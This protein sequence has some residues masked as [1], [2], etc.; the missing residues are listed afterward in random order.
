M[1]NGTMTAAAL[2][3]T[4]AAIM[5]IH[6]FFPGSGQRTSDEMISVLGAI[7]GS[8]AP[9]IEKHGGRICWISEAGISAVF[10]GECDRALRCA[11]EICSAPALTSEAASAK[12]TVGIHYG[13]VSM[14]TLSCGSFSSF[15]AISD[16][17][18]LA[19]RVS[20]LAVGFGA[21]ILVTAAA[22]ERIRDFGSRFSS[23][24]LGLIHS[25]CDG[26][27]TELYDVFDGDPADIKYKKRR[28]K[29]FFEKGVELFLAE[30]YLQA[31]S[32]FI[33]LLRFDR[34]DAPAKEYVYKCDSFISDPQQD[35]SGK[36][37]AVI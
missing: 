6:V 15:I 17:N 36:Y 29:L 13:S 37:L 9:V 18:S 4:E 30:S 8:A 3:K 21:V 14:G 1:D 23:R 19:R 25:R 10:E 32:Y 22:A 16:D 5:N 28:S 24:R 34:S 35:G 12:L 33:E 27:D 2:T 20:E 31:R 11:A 7:L 26:R